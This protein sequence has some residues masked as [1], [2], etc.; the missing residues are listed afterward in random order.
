ME[1]TMRL[2]HTSTGI[3][4]SLV[5]AGG[6][7]MAVLAQSDEGL[8]QVQNLIKKA[9]TTIESVNETKAQ[10]QK[11]MD[12]YNAVLAPETTD[13]RDAYKKLQK[14]MSSTDKKRMETQKKADEMNVEADKLF[15]SWDGST[16]AIANPDLRKRSAERLQK[17]KDTYSEIR[18]TGQSAGTLYSPFIKSLQDQVAFL[19]HD[20]NASAVANLKPDADKLNTQ[21]KELYAAIDKVTAAAN[22][23]I[24][25]LKPE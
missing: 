15:K 1:V 13:R 21:A 7:S 11:T 25:R 18:Q 17:T 23:N 6:I 9:N 22:N 19:G 4:L 14:E 12:A 3:A 16:A 8:K 5:F 2:H 20:L 10:I 24:S